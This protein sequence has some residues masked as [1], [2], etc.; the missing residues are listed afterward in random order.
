VVQAS[1]LQS[2]T[3]SMTI[4]SGEARLR[5]ARRCRAMIAP[6][7]P[8]ES[9]DTSPHSE[10]TYPDFHVVPRSQQGSFGNWNRKKKV[11]LSRFAASRRL[12][13]AVGYNPR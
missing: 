1:S 3:E 12:T 4:W 7:R 2:Q 8:I 9:S 13:L 11:I 10:C 6:S 5:F